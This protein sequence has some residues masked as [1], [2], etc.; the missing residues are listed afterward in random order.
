MRPSSLPVSFATSSHGFVS[1]AGSAD[2]V[3]TAI[4]FS[5][6]DFSFSL[7]CDMRLWPSTFGGSGGRANHFDECA[8]WVVTEHEAAGLMQRAAT[9][10]AAALTPCVAECSSDGGGAHLVSRVERVLRVGAA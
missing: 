5:I 10:P 8:K 7:L 2:F 6:F 3:V 9:A 1:T 4:L